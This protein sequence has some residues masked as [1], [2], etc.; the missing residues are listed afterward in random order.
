[1]PEEQ[2]APQAQVAGREP[3][4]SLA[5]A[6]LTSTR[7]CVPIRAARLLPKV[8]FTRRTRLS[9]DQCAASRDYYDVCL[10]SSENNE[11]T[12]VP[13]DVWGVF[14]PT[15][16]VIYSEGSFSLCFFPS[17]LVA[18][19]VDVRTQVLRRACKAHTDGF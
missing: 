7:P 14:R 6:N 2:R 16:D 8:T 13:P 9:G 18:M 19:F 17:C 11:T 3:S 4:A 12:I 1:L 15:H 5:D 10:A